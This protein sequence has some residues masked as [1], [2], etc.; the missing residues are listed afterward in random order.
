MLKFSQVI[1]QCPKVTVFSKDL[2]LH[3]V[4]VCV[5]R[6][7]GLVFVTSQDNGNFTDGAFCRR[8]ETICW[9][10]RFGVNCYGDCI[11]GFFALIVSFSLD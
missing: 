9:A 5:R 11:D 10:F 6:R 4:H 1:S 8:F 2:V 7:K 3:N